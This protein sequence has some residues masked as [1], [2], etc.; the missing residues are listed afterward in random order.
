MRNDHKRLFPVQQID[1]L[2][3]RAFRLVVECACRFVQHEH[4]R[5]LVQRTRNADA[6]PLSAG[7]LYAAL[8]DAGMNAFFESVHKGIE[9]RFL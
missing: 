3:D 7:K 2:H 1:G 5:I 8:A 4:L 9:L 6:L